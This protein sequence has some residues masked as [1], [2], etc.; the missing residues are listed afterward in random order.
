MFPAQAPPTRRPGSPGLRVCGPRSHDLKEPCSGLLRE[1]G[2]W[3][4][5]RQPGILGSRQ[6][7]EGRKAAPCVCP[8]GGAGRRRPCTPG[9]RLSRS[10]VLS[11][12][13]WQPLGP[14][15]AQSE[16]SPSWEPSSCPDP[17]AEPDSFG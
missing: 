11:A 5:R 13:A 6:R 17:A 12:A 9:N 8:G 14:A 4:P 15:L 2:A 3:G 10:P 1:L 16:P 7:Q